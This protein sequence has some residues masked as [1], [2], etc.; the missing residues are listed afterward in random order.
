MT[1]V[2]NAQPVMV[3]KVTLICPERGKKNNVRC[4][5]EDR[6]PRSQ[7]SGVRTPTQVHLLSQNVCEQ[8]ICP[9]PGVGVQG[10]VQV[11][12][13]D[14]FRVDDMG[15]ALHT[16]EPLQSLQK[17]APGHA[18]PAARGPH[19]HQAVVD[20]GDLIELE[21]LRAR[22]TS[23]VSTPEKEGGRFLTASP[24]AGQETCAVT[25]PRQVLGLSNQRDLQLATA[26]QTQRVFT[27]LWSCLT[28]S[29]D[30]HRAA[31]GETPEVPCREDRDQMNEPPV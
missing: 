6:V 29:G 7:F 3:S 28:E 20:L 4:Y 10:S 25:L 8:P 26:Q 17:N 19:H 22:P 23:T 1:E 31:S 18:L 2:E 24:T 16:L 14:G 5:H 9:F 11:V 27:E 12:F 30:A 21:N 13:A 15:H